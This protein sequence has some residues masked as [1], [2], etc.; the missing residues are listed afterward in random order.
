MKKLFIIPLLLSSLVVAVP[1]C[2]SDDP[3]QETG[4]PGTPD[5]SA[6][7]TKTLVVYFSAQ[8]HTQAVAE[9]I[10]ALTGAD[11][12]RIEASEPYSRNPYDDSD[13]I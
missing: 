7:N 9:R 3:V 1:A 12:Y 13:R 8:G 11:A 5:L 2:S 6:G 10:V 4:L